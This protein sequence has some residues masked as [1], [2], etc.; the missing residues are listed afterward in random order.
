MDSQPDDIPGNTTIDA[1]GSPAAQP[2]S[3]GAALR[4]ARVHIGLSVPD[5]ADRIKF[6][7]RQIEALE[8]DDFSHLP[9]I[10]FVRGFVRSYAKLLQLDP[11]PLLA[12]LPGAIS[13]PAPQPANT[14]AEVPFPN[15]YATHK[16]NIIWLAAAFAVALALA[17]FAWLY[18]GT[19]SAPKAPHEETLALP[20]AAPVPEAPE[21]E[22]IKAPQAAAPK[23]QQAAAP[24]AKPV[25]KPA[26]KPVAAGSASKQ[27]AAIRLVFDE[28]SWAE[29]TDK[30]GKVLLSQLNP[31]G[32]EQGINGDPPFSIVLGRASAVHLYYK[33]KAVDLAPHTR[34]E[35]THLKLE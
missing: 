23:V 27:T 4:G 31:R 30:D 26:T 10:T 5:V 14:L 3:V 7:P 11:A 17:L 20:A 15:V 32:S 29:V 33:G 35:V 12:A 16:P 6:A 21:A 13:Q 24:L 2:L 1:P 25:T 8:A 28:E 19:P 22:V 18:G 34:A 9:E